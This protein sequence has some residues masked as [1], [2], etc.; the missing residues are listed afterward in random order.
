MLIDCSHYHTT[1]KTPSLISFSSGSFILSFCDWN[2][3]FTLF[4][5]FHFAFISVCLS[6]TFNYFPFSFFNSRFWF[7]M[8]LYFCPFRLLRLNCHCSLTQNFQFSFVFGLTFLTSCFSASFIRF[9]H[10]FPI[11][12]HFL[13]SSAIEYRSYLLLFWY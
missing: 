1:K 12:L 5:L 9:L 8:T 2:I 13:L 11:I 10:S 7:L 6:V 3:P 4:C